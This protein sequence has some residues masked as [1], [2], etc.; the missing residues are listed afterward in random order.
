MWLLS[1]ITDFLTELRSRAK[2][3][4]LSFQVLQAAAG[5]LLS[6]TNSLGHFQIQGDKCLLITPEAGGCCG[7]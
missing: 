6:Q 4:F 7:A 1:K 3:V 5:A 2:S